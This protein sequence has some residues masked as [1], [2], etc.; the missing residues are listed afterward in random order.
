MKEMI[1][2]LIEKR[3]KI[4]KEEVL[5]LIEIPKDSKMGDFAIPCFA[6]AKKKKKNPA[7][8]AKEIEAK[9]NNEFEFEKVSAVGG[10][11]NIFVNRNVLA[12]ETIEQIQKEKDK[13]GSSKAG[14]NKKILIDFSSPN[15]AKPFGIGHLRSTIIG[16]SV[17]NLAE[18]QGYKPIRL[19]YLGDWG[20]QFGKL[21]VGYKKFG[22]LAKLK[23][24][25]INH[26]LDIYVRA[27]APE[28]EDEAREWFRKLELG[29]SEA[30]ELWRV[31]KGASIKEFDEV[32]KQL[33]IKFDAV[34][35]ESMYNK[36]MESV[37]HELRK[38]NIIEESEGAQIVDLNKYG[39]NVAL[40]KKSD[41]A[42][43]YATR[44]LA[45]AI[46]RKQKYK[47][48]KMFYE[49]GSE[50]T[51]HFRQ[52]FKILELLGNSWAKDC[53]HIS[54][55]LYLDKDGKK[56]ATRKGKTV[57]MQ[58]ILDE[59]K[60][61]AEK[62]ILKREEKIKKS[63]LEER[64]KAI[65]LAAIF[66]GDLKNYRANDMIFDIERFTSFEGDTGPYLLYSY[67]RAKSILRKAGH[68]KYKKVKI[69]KLSDAEKS[70]IS[71]LSQFPEIAS[72]A[73]TNLSPN[74]IANYAFQLSQN[75][76]EFYHK[77]Q[78][79]GS[80]SQQFKLLLVECFSQVLKNALTLLGIPVLEKM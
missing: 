32:Y 4:K 76:N 1:A 11:V 45:A 38:K 43:L 50:Q 57:F 15:I 80:E 53:A 14:K 12:Q 30:Y 54:H 31:F 42:T 58:D 3:M 16:N 55:G 48:D 44:D 69:E 65:A 52:V 6:L 71:Q 10:F 62:E 33:N 29:D 13:Y 59:A 22:S 2:K 51:L 56:F 26:L 35:G 49:A 41:G 7:E 23:K 68:K 24:D 78:V 18:F 39:L 75:F 40:I 34:T 72:N 25:P 66:Y 46:K 64:A 27:N 47:F 79:I 70:L 8:I 20:T 73:Y 28:F 60:S 67:A 9:I 19:N 63:D 5:R 61:L 21:I 36:E 74:L 17:A 77:E 37:I